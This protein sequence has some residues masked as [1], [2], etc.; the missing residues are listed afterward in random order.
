MNCIFLD[1]ILLYC[2][3]KARNM[4]LNIDILQKYLVYT[5]IASDTQIDL[6]LD[7]FSYICLNIWILTDSYKSLVSS[8]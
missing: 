8:H 1:I 5:I 2:E 7:G 4:Y 6:D 3:M